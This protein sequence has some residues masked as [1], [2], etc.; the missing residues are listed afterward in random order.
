MKILYGVVGEGMGHAIRSRVVLE[1]LTGAGHEVEII[2]S[3]RA[4]DYLKER[5][6]EVHRIHGLHIVTEDNRVRK[7]KTLWQNVLAG[8]AAIPQQVASYLQLID[9]FKPE[10]VISDFESWSYFYGKAH[11][12]PTISL[13]NMQIINRCKHPPEILD[14]ERANFEVT[15]AFIKSKLPFCDH[16]LITTFFHPPLRKEHT[17]LVP[18][19][20]RDQILEAKPIRGEHL[21]V[22][23]TATGNQALIDALTATGL[24]CR[25]YGMRRD[26]S[27]E[28]VEGNLRFRPFSEEGFVHDLATARAVVASAGFTLMGECVYLH[29]P[30]LAIPVAGQFE[31]VINARYLA[32]EG[33]GHTAT[34][35]NADSLR[36]FIN[37]IPACE[38]AL[39]VYRQDGNTMLFRTLDE[40]LDRATAGVY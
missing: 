29:K 16:Y 19:I 22:Y 39:A 1:H 20:L 13:D 15:R 7:G 31:Q 4:V 24:E 35:A 30:L 32:R 37:A 36:T 28:I 34:Q 14:G 8:T 38:S 21:L 3:S 12:I 9:D 26:L 40:H 10:A 6:S 33:Y 5:F 2:A 17:T 25:I 18:P 11:R 23:Q 27:E